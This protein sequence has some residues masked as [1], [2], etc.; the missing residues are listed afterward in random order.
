MGFKYV[1]RQHLVERGAT[2][3]RY[4]YQLEPDHQGVRVAPDV[5]QDDLRKYGVTYRVLGEETG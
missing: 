3:L 5:R 4:E 2:E 1:A